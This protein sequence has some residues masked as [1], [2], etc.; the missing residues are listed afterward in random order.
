MTKKRISA[1]FNPELAYPGL[2]KIY[3]PLG[4]P[5]QGNSHASHSDDVYGATLAGQP[6]ML[7]GNTVETRLPTRSTFYSLSEEARALTLALFLFRP[8]IEFNSEKIQELAAQHNITAE[9]I[10]R[11]ET[12][13]NSPNFYCMPGALTTT[14]AH[15]LSLLNSGL[16]LLPLNSNKPHHTISYALNA[17]YVFS[18]ALTWSPKET[19]LTDPLISGMPDSQ[20]VTKMIPF[21]DGQVT[22]H[23]EMKLE[24]DVQDSPPLNK[25]V[26]IEFSEDSSP[27]FI[28]AFEMLS[29]FG[30]ALYIPQNIS[31][32]SS[33]DIIDI[34]PSSRASTKRKNSDGDTSSESGED[35]SVKERYEQLIEIYPSIH[36]TT[37]IVNAFIKAKTKIAEHHNTSVE[38]LDLTNQ[39]IRNHIIALVANRQD[40][41]LTELDLANQE[42][43]NENI[44]KQRHEIARQN[45]LLVAK[46]ELLKLE[47]SRNSMQYG[48]VKNSMNE[49]INT[50]KKEYELA[51]NSGRDINPIIEMIKDCNTLI[52]PFSDTTT[53]DWTPN[54]L[55][56]V[57]SNAAQVIRKYSP[58]LGSNKTHVSHTAAKMVG[59]GIAT[60]LTAATI[61]ALVVF[62]PPVGA[63]LGI[64]IGMLIHAAIITGGGLSAAGVGYG[65]HKVIQPR[66]ASQLYKKLVTNNENKMHKLAIAS[67]DEAHILTKSSANTPSEEPANTVQVKRTINS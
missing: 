15:F 63:G 16:I 57:H 41:A 42:M 55:E 9:E 28:A 12:F 1:P 17:D 65:L 7:P 62:C 40:D 23:Y 24:N 13:I 11:A 27:E 52:S 46:N 61:A 45:T 64:G 3:V 43:I 8:N 49:L 53:T 5:K 6:V 34:G 58:L 54:K 48:L 35:I 60:L 31:L 44:E 56:D 37:Q 50:L 51:V 26:S 21:L 36:E 14:E 19:Y 33:K 18:S 10:K 67:S 38:E 47:S 20:Q 29:L 25:L 39:T 30:N 22:Y 32:P 59:L 4:L 66:I 2:E